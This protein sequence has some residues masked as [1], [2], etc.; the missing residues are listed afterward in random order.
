MM[1]KE[2]SWPSSSSSVHLLARKSL[3]PTSIMHCAT[4]TAGVFGIKGS[5]EACEMVARPRS[6]SPHS[7][8]VRVWANNYDGYILG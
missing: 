2:G 6:R 3:R 5:W 8:G 4:F 1:F 7:M